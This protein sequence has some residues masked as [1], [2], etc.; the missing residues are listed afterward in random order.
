MDIEFLLQDAYTTLRPQWKL[1]NT[2]EEA[3][4]AFAQACKDNYAIANGDKTAGNVETDRDEDID[5]D[6]EDGGRRTPEV[7]DDGSS[8]DEAEVSVTDTAQFIHAIQFIH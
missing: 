5:E 2:L 6:V 4:N 1:L 8:A 3:G 7:R